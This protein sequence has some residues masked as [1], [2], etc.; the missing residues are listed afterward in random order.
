MKQKKFFTLIEV[1]IVIILV[2][3]LTGMITGNF[4]N[5]LKKARDARR[6]SDLEQIKKALELYYEDKGGYPQTLT[7]GSELKDPATGKIYMSR[8]PTDPISPDYF[9]QSDGTYFRIYACLENDQQVLPYEVSSPS[10]FNCQRRCKAPGGSREV[11][12]IW[13]LSSDNVNP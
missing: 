4:L 6:K 3:S 2:G 5:S 1:L 12:C 7:F 8:L 10:Q 13:G 11:N 9:Y